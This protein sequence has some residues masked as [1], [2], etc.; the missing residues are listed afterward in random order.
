MVKQLL[1][2]NN[3]IKNNIFLAPI[4]GYTNYA[5]RSLALQLGYGLCF[6]ELVSA[7]G[8][9]YG[10]SGTKELLLA[11]NGI[12]NTAVQLFGSDPYYLRKA[13][14]SEELKDFS[15]VDINMGCPVPKVYKNGEGSALLNDVKKAEAVVK[16]AVK[17]CKTIT[18]KIRIGQKESE[19][20]VTEEFAKMLEGAGVS[21]LTIHA[22]TREQYYSGK[23]YFDEIYKAK[24]AVK[25]PVI[26]NGGIFTET[27]ADE[28]ML[29]TGADGIM[30]ARGAIA[31]PFL[32]SSLTNTKAQFTL[33]ELIF[34]QISDMLE[35][36]SDRYTTV[37][38]RKF[39]V[40]YF[41]GRRNMKKLNA[42]LYTCE[43]TLDLIN[44]LKDNYHLI[45][46]E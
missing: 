6:T 34:M 19:P 14:E 23:V 43:N 12:N 21:M 20:F 44:C 28:M 18:A 42:M 25:I 40:Y 8:L 38:M 30:L 3:L 27:D 4:A 31:N 1:V 15:I 7:K 24:N 41:K 16:S 33:K 32:F 29:K 9:V 11:E 46:E 26:A 17:S 36:Y 35:N 45:E 37:N 10:N 2:G 22:R 5:F 39:F 13:C